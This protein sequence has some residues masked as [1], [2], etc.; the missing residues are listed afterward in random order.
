M[1]VFVYA[2]ENIY[3]GLH[4]INSMGVFEVDDLDEANDIGKE[5]SYEVI[6]SFSGVFDSYDEIEVQEGV[7]W[8]VYRIRSEFD[9]K[10]THELDH[11]CA[12]LDVESFVEEY[13]EHED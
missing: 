8:E 7:E 3:C 10:S 6:E 4:G 2:Y 12:T 5:L 1:R 13:C 9:N 11:I